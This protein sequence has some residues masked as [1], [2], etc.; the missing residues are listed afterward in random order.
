MGELMSK[1]LDALH[2]PRIGIAKIDISTEGKHGIGY[3]PFY[4]T[5]QYA[6]IEEELKA[7]EIVRKT[8]STDLHFDYEEDT[9]RW[10]VWVDCE[11]YQVYIFEG[12]GKEAYDLLREVLL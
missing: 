2:H 3:M 5:K 6:A 10:Y 1:G 9:E 4:R 12:Q 8:I 7:L 11:G